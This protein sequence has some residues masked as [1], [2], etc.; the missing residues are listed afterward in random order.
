ML[1]GR[2]ADPS[3]QPLPGVSLQAISS[4]RK[5]TQT[6]VTDRD[7]RYE[8][9]SLPAGQYALIFSI[10][11]FAEVR[12]RDVT[13]S[14]S[15]PARLDVTMQLAVNAT[16]VVTGRD[17]FRN[18]AELPKPARV[19]PRSRHRLRDDGGRN[20]GESSESRARPGIF[21]P[22]LPDSRAGLRRAVQEGT[23][24]GAGR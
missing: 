6:T 22:Q 11:N 20:P 5:T 7:G 21:G 9:T 15:A 4:D 12:R 2:V 13:I 14:P 1:A 10:P 16:V 24:F 17:T 18:L 23:V 8:L 3:G 19:Q